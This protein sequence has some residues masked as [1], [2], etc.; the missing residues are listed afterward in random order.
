M[1]NSLR[2]YVIEVFIGPILPTLAVFVLLIL[3]IIFSQHD[4]EYFCSSSS[5]TPVCGHAAP[6]RMNGLTLHAL[7]RLILESKPASQHANPPEVY[8]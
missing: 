6:V 7:L 5:G 8:H 1:I 4:R 3:S 2:S